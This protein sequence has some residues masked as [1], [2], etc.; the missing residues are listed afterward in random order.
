[1]HPK[2]LTSS[3]AGLGLALLVLVSGC[4]PPKAG[5]RGEPAGQAER[6][7]RARLLQQCRADLDRC[8]AACDGGTSST[9]LE[10]HACSLLQEEGI[11]GAIALRQ[12]REKFDQ[13]QGKG[14]RRDTDATVQRQATLDSLR[15]LRAALVALDDV[16][17]LA[18]EDR[19][20]LTVEVEARLRAAEQQHP[21][22]LL[23]PQQVE[24]LQ[25]KVLRL[26]ERLR[27]R[28]KKIASEDAALGAA[29]GGSSCEEKPTA[30]ATLCQAGDDVACVARA[31][32][33]MK[34]KLTATSA[35]DAIKVGKAGC[36]RGVEFGCVAARLAEQAW[37]SHEAHLNEGWD[38]VASAITRIAEIRFGARMA[39]TFAPSARN[40]RAAAA[41]ERHAALLVG[42]TFCPARAA[43]VRRHGAPAFA[44]RSA[45]FCTDE[46]P[47]SG[48]PSGEEV[49][50]TT[51]CRAVAAAPCPALHPEP[52]AAARAGPPLVGAKDAK[53]RASCPGAPEFV[54][55]T[56]CYC[57]CMGM[58]A[59]VGDNDG[60][61][62]PST[63]APF[64]EEA[65][66]ASLRRAARSARLCTKGAG[67]GEPP[68]VHVTIAPSGDIAAV[69]VDPPIIGRAAGECI[70]GTFK[71]VR[72]EPFAPP[73][74]RVSL[75]VP[76]AAED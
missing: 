2:P 56:N 48:S 62:P 15:E 71:G 35:A 64:H 27:A 40:M 19:R 47:R 17:V 12:A 61:D 69:L 76:L 14:V 3:P 25:R 74:A 7:A 70:I 57:V 28:A 41:A 6:H 5:K 20:R 60:S 34:A 18:D 26:D 67:L 46:A 59:E 49:A 11:A 58:C 52:P 53:C 55:N 29:L 1:M 9:P 4:I 33:A 63:A 10:T 39:R 72:L 38:D 24:A 36:D 32:G 16:D 21:G 68:K 65:V 37:R 44:Q 45:T 8:V 73:S 42:D 75:E 22:W 43:Y 30:C 54:T 66:G 13:E 50:L 51:E 23:S 31:L